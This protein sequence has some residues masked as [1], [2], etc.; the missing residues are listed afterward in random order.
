ML[1][2]VFSGSVFS[3][4][5]LFSEC[6]PGVFMAFL[7][8]DCHPGTILLGNCLPFPGRLFCPF[9]A[10]LFAPPGGVQHAHDFNIFQVADGPRM[11]TFLNRHA[12]PISSFFIIPGRL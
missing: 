8:A 3:V 11:S 6:A 7:C 12:A 1:G 9:F 5:S 4:L 2:R 10:R